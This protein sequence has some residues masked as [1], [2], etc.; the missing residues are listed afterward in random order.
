MNTPQANTISL[1]DAGLA[2]RH[3]DLPVSRPDAAAQATAAQCRVERITD[4]A[5]LGVVKA[6]MADL[7]QTALEPALCSEFA[8]VDAALSHLTD[9]AGDVCVVLV[10]RQ[11]M[12]GQMLIGAFL[13]RVSRTLPLLPIYQMTSWKHLFSPL[14]TPL[15]HRDHGR[16]ALETYFGWAFGAD[17]SASSIMWELMPA[18]GPFADLLEDAALA[19]GVRTRSINA[20]RRA[21]LEVPDSLDTYLTDSLPRKKRKELRRLRTRLGEQG[22]VTIEQFPIGGDL[23]KWL[24]DFYALEASGWKGRAGTALS[25]DRNWTGFFD[26]ALTGLDEQ[27]NVLFWKLCLDGAPVAMTFGV[28]RGRHAWL[29]KIAYDEAHARFSPGVL[30]VLDV[31][32]ILAEDAGIDTVDSCAQADHPMIDHLWRERLDMHDIVIGAPGQSSLMF[33]MICG[34]ANLKRTAR[35]AAKRLYTKFLKGG[36]K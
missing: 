27:G 8:W 13:Q 29:C 5:L 10:W 3:A 33:T 11:D 9:G 19:A 25:C 7:A 14:C 12:E 32:G 6:P 17:G 34:I 26:R 31:M 16:D 28:K 35:A 36:R 20:Y 21:M 24:K 23:A 30:I 15:L 18:S 1:R 2:D 4:A 22:R